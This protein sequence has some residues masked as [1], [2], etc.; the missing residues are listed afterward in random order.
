MKQTYWRMQHLIQQALLTMI[1]RGS[2]GKI[3]LD[4]SHFLQSPLNI[5]VGTLLERACSRWLTFGLLQ[6]CH[7][8]EFRNKGSSNISVKEKKISARGFCIHECQW[9]TGFALHLNKVKLLVLWVKFFFFW[10][11]KQALHYH[12]YHIFLEWDAVYLLIKALFWEESHKGAV[13]KL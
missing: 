10:E 3:L 4:T 5:W 11:W 2:W 1:A 7:F 9:Y 12:S 8:Y 13:W 6:Y